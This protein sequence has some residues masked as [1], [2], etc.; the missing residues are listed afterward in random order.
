[1][2]AAKSHKKAKKPSKELVLMAMGN[3]KWDYR[4]VHGIAI[5]TKL[6]EAVVLNV[7]KESKNEIRS[8]IIRTKSGKNLYALKNRKSAIADVW[9]AIKKM[10]QDKYEASDDDI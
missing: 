1:M 5:E 6:P 3:N 2:S 9:W 7:L 10:S 4:T 8:S